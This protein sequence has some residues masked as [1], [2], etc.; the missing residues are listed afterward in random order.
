MKALTNLIGSQRSLTSLVKEYKYKN[1]F[2]SNWDYLPAILTNIF[3]VIFSLSIVIELRK[4]IDNIIV[5]S[6]LSVFVVFFLIMNE[7]IKVKEIRKVYR[8]FKN[9]IISFVVTFLIS[10]TLA[11]IGMYFFTNKSMDVKDNSN[12]N[13]SIAINEIKLKFED[14]INNVNNNVFENSETYNSLNKE[15]YYWKHVSAATLI[16]R[17]DIRLRIDKLQNDIQK[18]R[19]NFNNN[20]D[21]QV[22]KL[23]ELQN[24]EISVTESKYNKVMNTTK[25]N[26]FITYIFL[27]LIFV[28]EFATIV[29]NKH[30]VEKQLSLDEFVNGDLAKMYTVSSNIL[31]TLYMTSRNNE[32]NIEKAKYSYSNKDNVLSWEDITRLYNILIDLGILDNGEIREID[33]PNGNVKKLLYNKFLVSESEAHQIFDNYFEKYFKIA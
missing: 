12:I 31:T 11:S 3:S 5:L 33:L 21:S 18:E 32:T 23:I 19:I 6:I 10:I 20:K 15:L 22:K 14:K 30:I 8:G 25:K 7:I 4:C 24:N 29:L 17:N 1:S 9:S 13:L 2:I 16:E 27:S 26:D 28:T